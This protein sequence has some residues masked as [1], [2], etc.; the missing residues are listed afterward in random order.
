[1]NIQQNRRLIY[2]NSG[3]HSGQGTIFGVL[4]LDVDSH[5]TYLDFDTGV[6]HRVLSRIYPAEWF[7]LE[8]HFSEKNIFAAATAAASLSVEQSQ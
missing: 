6:L 7:G 2:I 8:S 3:R 1:M 5:E 4:K